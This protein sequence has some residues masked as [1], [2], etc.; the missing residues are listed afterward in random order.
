MSIFNKVRLD[1]PKYST[2]NLSHDR[3]MSLNMGI[4]TPHL[5]MEVLP[6]DN[7][8]LKTEQMLRMMPMVAPVMHEVNV[9]MHYF[10]VPNRII[11]KDWEKFITG[12]ESGLDTAMLPYINISDLTAYDDTFWKIGSLAD[13]LGL[14]VSNADCEGNISLL[15]FI[16]YQYIYNEYYRDQNLEPEDWES[17]FRQIV[18]GD[19]VTPLEE[20]ALDWLFTMRNRAWEHDYFTSALPWAQKGAQVTLPLGDKAPIVWEPTYDGQNPE[21]DKIRYPDGT[22]HQDGELGISGGNL[23]RE[24]NAAAWLDNSKSLHADLSEATASTIGDLRRAFS[25]Q[26]WLEKNARSGSRYVESILAHFGIHI[27]DGRV[28]RPE[29]LGGGKSPI[30]ISEV[31]QTSETVDSPQGNM[32]GHGLNLGNNSAFNYKCKEHGYIVGIMSILPR[33]AYQQG[34]HKHWFKFDKFDYYWKEFEGIGEQAILNKEIYAGNSNLDNEK[35]FGYIPRYAEYKFLN[36]SVHGYFRE[37]LSFWHM[38]RIFDAQPL[39]NDQFVKSNPTK[40]IFAVEDPDED[41]ILCHLFHKIYARRPM[42]Y[43]SEPGLTRL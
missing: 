20:G 33:T 32:A 26:Q 30:M 35:T 7:I 6:G 24:P 12:G 29:Y 39:L 13:Y 8:N 36:N 3:K 1:R 40:R 38:G 15:P 37:N 25:L 23:V 17:L 22:T 18:E 42:G 11:C 4:L 10:Y 19:N 14:P 31:L 43:W 9:F 41:V 2:F 16:A 5:L 34:I 28:Q 21:Q 27:G